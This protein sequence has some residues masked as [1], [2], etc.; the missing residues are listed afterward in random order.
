MVK[1]LICGIEKECSIVEHLKY[2]HQLSSKDYKQMFSGS[3]VKSDEE[4][5]KI[6][7]RSKKNWSDPNYKEQQIKKRNISHQDPTFKKK[8]SEIIK[9]K[10]AENP[11]L[12]TGLTQYHKTEKFKEWVVSKER[13]DK[14]S[15]TT[16]KRFDHYP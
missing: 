1:C 2:T 9:K 8:M 16:K 3:K 6:S 15:K 12:F 14:I 5:L 13:I 10:H 7:E 11:E 4:L